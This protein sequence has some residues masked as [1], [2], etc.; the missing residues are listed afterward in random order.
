M[1]FRLLFQLCRR[2]AAVVSRGVVNC[3]NDFGDINNNESFINNIINSQD[4][5]SFRKYQGFGVIG[6]RDLAVALS[7]RTA[8]FRP[9]G[10]GVLTDEGL[11]FKV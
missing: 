6:N 5:N 7:L 8:L 9:G 11:G 2:P 4:N 3:N 10:P 1:C